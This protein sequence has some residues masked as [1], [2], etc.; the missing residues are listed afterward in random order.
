MDRISEFY[1]DLCSRDRNRN[2]GNT[3]VHKIKKDIKKK[4]MHITTW[5]WPDAYLLYC[6]YINY[7]TH[8]SYA[9]LFVPRRF[10]P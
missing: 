10:V 8:I 5:R 6:Y 1:S 2:T 4:N 7:Y 3:Y 9:N